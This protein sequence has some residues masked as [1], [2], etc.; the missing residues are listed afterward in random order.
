MKSPRNRGLFGHLDSPAL[1]P[2]VVPIHEAWKV[3]APFALVPMKL[4]DAVPPIGIVALLLIPQPPFCPSPTIV[5]GTVF[6]VTLP[7]VWLV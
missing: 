2:E 1:L 7:V 6:T 3:D 5:S 4:I